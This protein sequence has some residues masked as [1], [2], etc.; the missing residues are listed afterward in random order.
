MLG[1]TLGHGGKACCEACKQGRKCESLKG[2]G[3]A[4]SSTL[5][6]IVSHLFWTAIFVGFFYA[7]AYCQERGIF[8]LVPRTIASR[9]KRK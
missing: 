3:Q 6:Q 5:S 9:K 2:L 7:G 4:D 1:Y 8:R